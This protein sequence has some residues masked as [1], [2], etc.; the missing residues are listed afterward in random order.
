[1]TAGSQR[2]SRGKHED[3]DCRGVHHAGEDVLR[4]ASLPNALA[5]PWSAPPSSESRCRR[6]NSRRRSRCRTAWPPRRAPTGAFRPAAEACE[7][8]CPRRTAPLRTGRARERDCAKNAGGVARGM[9][10][11]SAPPMRLMTNRLLIVSPGG[12]CASARPV[13][14]MTTWEGNSAT[15]EVMLA[16]RASMPVSMSAGNVMND[17]PPASA[18]CTP[19]HSEATKRSIGHGHRLPS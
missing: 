19:A 13:N 5:P 6:R 18:F 7:K 8:S 14:P 16:A 15:V 1:M 10:A 9:R 11:P 2:T 12:L 3:R 4:R 17:P